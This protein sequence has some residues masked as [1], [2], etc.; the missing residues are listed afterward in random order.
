[1]ENKENV[2]GKVNWPPKLKVTYKAEMEELI[3]EGVKINLLSNLEA[4]LRRY[5]AGQG[6]SD[7]DITEALRKYIEGK[8]TGKVT[9][10]TEVV[11]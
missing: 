9:K 2:K 8:P 3:K 10:P 5:L 1:M 7:K 4:D 6:K 11:R